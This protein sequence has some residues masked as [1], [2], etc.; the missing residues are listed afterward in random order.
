MQPARLTRATINLDQFRVKHGQPKK[1]PL[2]DQFTVRLAHGGLVED[3]EKSISLNRAV[4]RA[5]LRALKLDPA[6][7]YFERMD[8]ETLYEKLKDMASPFDGDP[9]AEGWF[10][11]VVHHFSKGRPVSVVADHWAN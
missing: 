11:T 5:I 4:W 3:R 9:E 7:A 10:K 8:V 1:Q 2:R 6:T